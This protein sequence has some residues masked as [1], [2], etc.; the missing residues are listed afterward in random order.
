MAALSA[1]EVPSVPT[2]DQVPVRRL[3]LEDA[4]PVGRMLARAFAED[5]TTAWLFPRAAGRDQA[6][7]RWYVLNTKILIASGEGWGTADLSSAALWLPMGLPSQGALRPLGRLLAWNLAT[8]AM[9]RTRVF[10]A[11]AT[12]LRMQRLHPKGP[13]WYL[14]IL[15]TEP[16]RQGRGMAS[17]VL[18]PILRRC[19]RLGLPAYLDTATAGDVAFYRG[20]GFLVVG[21]VDLPH[22]PH[23]WVMSR[24]ATTRAIPS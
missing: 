17:A 20:R 2:P 11:A 9:L 12:T 23:F 7:E 15:G 4:A 13:G 18:A 24:P 10:S 5:P 6:L 3:T 1:G 16:V 21:E 14:A 22:S 8:A 19:D